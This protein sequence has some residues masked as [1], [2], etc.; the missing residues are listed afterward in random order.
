MSAPIVGHGR[1][2]VV[3]AG[4]AV[5]LLGAGDCENFKQG[6]G[7]QMSQPP[8]EPTA[9]DHPPVHVLPGA[10]GKPVDNGSHAGFGYL[11]N[12]YPTLR[13]YLRHPLTD[14]SPGPDGRTCVARTAACGGAGSVAP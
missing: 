13:T 3:A 14:A 10:D 2:T 5:L 9:T 4:V 12:T 7:P 6:S 11:C 8:A 1:R